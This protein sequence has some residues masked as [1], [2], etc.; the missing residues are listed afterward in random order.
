MDLVPT[1][2]DGL[3]RIFTPEK[4]RED[5]T[6]ILVA[7]RVG[8]AVGIIFL[9]MGGV[10]AYFTGVNM[11][12]LEDILFWTSVVG[13]A[14]GLMTTTAFIIWEVIEA[15]R[16]LKDSGSI[17]QFPKPPVDEIVAPETVLDD[18]TSSTSSESTQED[19]K[20][21]VY[22]QRN[23]PNRGRSQS[24][25]GVGSL[26][27]RIKEIQI[28]GCPDPVKFDLPKKP[29]PVFFQLQEQKDVPTHFGKKIAE[30]SF[31]HD[32]PLDAPE[33]KP[34]RYSLNDQD[35]QGNT[36][37]HYVTTV[38]QAR[39]FMKAGASLEVINLAGQSPL[40]TSFQVKKPSPLFLFFLEHASPKI[41]NIADAKGFTMLTLSIRF[42]LEKGY[43][44]DKD[45]K[46]VALR[47][48]AKGASIQPSLANKQVTDLLMERASRNE[49][50]CSF[51]KELVVH[52]QKGCCLDTQDQEGNTL[53]HKVQDLSLA[54]ILIEAGASPGVLN[55]KRCTP[56]HFAA[57]KEWFPIF[58]KNAAPEYLAIEDVE[59]NLPLHQWFEKN[60]LS[61]SQ[62]NS[63]MS[64][65]A[66]V[67]CIDLANREGM[68][69]LHWA[70]QNRQMDLA[71]QFLE[72][73]PLT[74]A[75]KNEITPFHLVLK[76]FEQISS[77]FFEIFLQQISS[78]D[79]TFT[80]KENNTWL[81]ILVDFSRKAC[82]LTTKDNF[83]A[84]IVQLIKLG[85]DPESENLQK[86]KACELAKDVPFFLEA[87][88]LGKQALQTPLS[89]DQVFAL[90]G[91][92][93]SKADMIKDGYSPLMWLLNQSVF[94][95]EIYRRSF[96]ALCRGTNTHYTDLV[97][98]LFDQLTTEE[99]SW[100][101]KKGR[102]LLQVLL[103]HM[104]QAESEKIL[105]PGWEQMF[106]K[107]LNQKH[108]TLIKN[109]KS[110]LLH[111]LLEQSLNDVPSW[112]ID[113]LVEQAHHQELINFQDMKGNTPLYLALKFKKFTLVQTLMAKG[114]N[115]TLANK[116]GETALSL[117]IKKCND[118]D[119]FAALFSESTIYA[120]DSDE[121]TWLHHAAYQDNSIAIAFLQGKIP[122]L[123]K[124]KF[125]KTPLQVAQKQKASSAI[126]ENGMHEDLLTQFHKACKVE[127]GWF[128][129]S[130]RV[131]D[132]PNPSFKLYRLIKEYIK[133]FGSTRGKEEIETLLRK[134]TSIKHQ[135]T[136]LLH[137]FLKKDNGYIISQAHGLELVS[138]LIEA[139]SQQ[140]CL[141]LPDS[142]GVT[143][144]M[145]CLQKTYLDDRYK[146]V[147]LKMLEKNVS[148]SLAIQNGS[149]VSF[150]KNHKDIEFFAK[151]VEKAK[152]EGCL[153]TQDAVGNT[154][155]HH[156]FD[157]KEGLI[158]LKAG[159]SLGIVN[160]NQE[161]PLHLTANLLSH[162]IEIFS[163]LATYATDKDLGILNKDKKTA[164][165][166]LLGRCFRNEV[167]QMLDLPVIS[168]H[169]N[170]QDAE[171]CTLT[172]W[173]IQSGNYLLLGRLL[174]KGGSL[175]IQDHKGVAP[176]QLLHH[177]LKDWIHFEHL[178]VEPEHLDWQ[179]NNKETFLHLAIRRNYRNIILS[180]I[181]KKADIS[182]RDANGMTAQML[183]ESSTNP[184]LQSL[185]TAYKDPKYQF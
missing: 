125:G 44:F 182:I 81:H 169:I 23:L 138:L 90:F 124:N 29:S 58:L 136:T 40:Q 122:V 177:N 41:V 26:Q 95:Q 114:S 60:R 171:G 39:Q 103:E 13:S 159:A 152:V 107:L 48:L 120:L 126:N 2:P 144:L 47:L 96:R 99:L 98:Y 113:R 55:H 92:D 141:N 184:T 79:V 53:L 88:K 185:P 160:Q 54:E 175:F 84:L 108:F 17:D 43:P 70:L 7:R 162:K 167:E 116:K 176:L 52:A 93:C 115:P 69:L 51:F 42:A 139:A 65:P 50:V 97:S 168:N 45:W 181:R 151:I 74:K 1:N 32:T 105:L 78:K 183:L 36:V 75:D 132:E 10:G 38:D 5:S 109:D 155:L 30:C 161:T 150:F 68:T 164:I 37:L 31:K 9:V 57:Q 129:A 158:L 61:K 8:I 130:D 101:D 123:A 146:P 82:W 156:F 128:S 33:E 117:A 133:S 145:F 63:V 142:E 15:N 87:V 110:T 4:S 21:P 137:W 73:V 102:T 71:S 49:A 172:H 86:Q 170:L 83:T 64:F 154:L 166:M 24:L 165:Y 20:P 112:Y 118:L 180:L 56:L 19:P 178:I 174:S 34:P 77:E 76:N 121:N 127:N 148:V 153:N 143:P 104:I 163:L 134:N 100:Q 85:I 147:I 66:V 59:G 62:I 72:H 3:E 94:K 67:K 16:S 28:K 25:N 131:T 12:S 149:I 6:A 14:L 140:Q 111:W 173:A 179:G 11:H 18:E 89:D 35:G 91:M 22:K 46:D 135:D 119:T 106:L 80:D 157:Q 27:K